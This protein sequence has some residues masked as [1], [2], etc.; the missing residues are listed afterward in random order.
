MLLFQ[1]NSTQIC[2]AATRA[3]FD[4]SCISVN[5]PRQEVSGNPFNIQEPMLYMCICES[6][7]FPLSSDEMQEVVDYV[8][9]QLNQLL[10]DNSSSNCQFMPI[11]AVPGSVFAFLSKSI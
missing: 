11:E 10:P 5:S 4:I 9:M 8:E 7:S 3:D 1:K 2:C 6:N